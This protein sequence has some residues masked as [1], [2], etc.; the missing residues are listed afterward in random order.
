[1]QCPYC[2]HEKSK[3]VDKRNLAELRAIRR[4]R[5][6]V[7]CQRRFTTYERATLGNIQVQKK[8]GRL[9][10]GFSRRARSVRSPPNG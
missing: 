8:D 1:M 10:A 4:R 3:V 9:Q 2:L 7:S 5:E 6:C